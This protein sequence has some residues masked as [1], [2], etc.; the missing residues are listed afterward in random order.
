VDTRL[1]ELRP[2]QAHRFFVLTDQLNRT[3]D[4]RVWR[5]GQAHSLEDNVSQEDAFHCYATPKLA[6]LLNVANERM[7]RPR[8][9]EVQVDD[10]N[11]EA[12]DAEVFA[13]SVTAVQ[14]ATMPAL[15]AQDFA[16]FAVLSAREAFSSGLLGIEFASWSKAWLSGQDRSGEE[17]RALSDAL[18]TEAYRFGGGYMHPEMLA[19]AHAARTAVHAARTAYLGGRARDEE[20]ARTAEL[21]A[22]AV[23]LASRVARLDLVAL[24]EQAVPDARLNAG[25]GSSKPNL[26]LARRIA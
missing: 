12:G 2:R 18:E 13:T 10:L 3:P 7:H 22:E 26:G 25:P 6:A 19:A 5:E 1:L 14:Q 8:L 15:V 4:G 16:R 21:A 20:T 11:V 23:H 24:A 9:W 17:A